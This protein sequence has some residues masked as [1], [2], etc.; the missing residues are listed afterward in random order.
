MAVLTHSKVGQFAQGWKRRNTIAKSSY[1]AV[2]T[3]PNADKRAMD[4]LE[5]APQ[6]W[7]MQ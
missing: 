5:N 2:A 6:A 3:F 1:W 4:L 7:A